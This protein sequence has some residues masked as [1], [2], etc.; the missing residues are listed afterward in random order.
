MNGLRRYGTYI[1]LNIT[2]HKKDKLMPTYSNMGGTRDSYTKWSKSE[3]KRQIP[4]DY[5][6]FV[7]S[8]IWHR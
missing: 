4:Y 6:L 8:K 5:H 3:R 2:S 1:Q 7:G